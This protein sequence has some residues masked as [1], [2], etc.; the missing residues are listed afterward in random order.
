MNNFDEK[1]GKS[2][3]GL[4]NA[5]P[6]LKV[7]VL[8][9]THEEFTYVGRM[10]AGV[11]LS[12]PARNAINFLS[13]EKSCEELSQLLDTPIE[14]IN[15]LIT[16]LN[17]AELLDTKATKIAVHARFHSPNAHRASHAGDDSSDGAFQQLKARLVPELTSA[18]CHAK[19]K[20][21]GVSIV[22]SRRDW[23]VNIF[24]DSR[25]ATLLYG[26]LLSSGITHTR[27]HL[28]Q[29]NRTITERDLCAGSLRASDIGLSFRG[30]L[31]EL[32]RELSLFP[33]TPT[34]KTDTKGNESAG[35]KG[36]PAKKIISI[37]VGTPPSDQLQ[38]WMSKGI[39]HL[40]VD[41]PD[42]ASVTIG[43]LVIP[44]KTPCT[45]C[46]SITN[47][48]LNE[49][50]RDIAWKKQNSP[51]AEVPVAVAHHIAGFLALELLAFLDEGRSK[52]VGASVRINFHAPTLIQE[53][54]FA[55]HPACGCTW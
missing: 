42:G 20:D 34:S 50:W 36:E 35:E 27:L 19:A 5:N 26:I 7:G 28:P 33:T 46:V 10:D 31:D 11:A 1:G 53:R 44:G 22:N 23:Q 4:K 9:V 13:G 45:R 39:A 49:L 2:E 16:E 37:V 38:I 6:R 51:A 40:L 12:S 18:T 54:L 17:A 55:R 21:G 8:V 52:L 24:G 47:E 3:V 43:P 32:A 14:E 41:S 30:R 25:I 48:D 29:E 15:N